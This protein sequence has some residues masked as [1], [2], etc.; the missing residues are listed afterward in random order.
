VASGAVPAMT[1]GGCT[2]TTSSAEHPTEAAR[3]SRW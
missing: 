1:A 3:T 2:S